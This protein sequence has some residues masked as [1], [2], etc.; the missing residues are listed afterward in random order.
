MP[1]QELPRLSE[2]QRAVAREFGISEE[3]YARN[4]YASELSRRELVV[5]AERF[6][7]LLQAI[8]REKV[9]D[10]CVHLVELRTFDGKFQIVAIVGGRD[11]RLKVNEDLVDDL[12]SSGSK[13]I[14]AR[15]IRIVELNLPLADVARAS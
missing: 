9:P 2:E 3:G 6:G 12:L 15:L 1:A 5:K 10:A 7:E 11:V 4:A 8:M 14:Q 13:D